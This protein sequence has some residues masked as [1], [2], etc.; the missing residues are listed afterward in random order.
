MIYITLGFGWF[1][2]GFGY[3]LGFGLGTRM[4]CTYTKFHKFAS[5]QEGLG[6][7]NKLARVREQRVTV[8]AAWFWG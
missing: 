3:G 7:G 2:L 6:L 1:G 5:T 4:H 8:V